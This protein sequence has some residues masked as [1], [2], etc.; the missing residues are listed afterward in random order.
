MKKFGWVENKAAGFSMVELMVVIAVI[1]MLYFLI[2]QTI[3][4]KL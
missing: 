3:P 2:P 4:I 1:A